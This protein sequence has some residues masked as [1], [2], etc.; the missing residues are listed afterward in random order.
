M[1]YEA[2]SQAEGSYIDINSQEFKAWFGNSKIVDKNNNPLVVY[3]GTK[4]KF[5]G[6]ERDYMG[7]NFSFRFGKGFYFTEIKENTSAYGDNLLSTYLCIKNP[8]IVSS[9]KEYKD[10]VEKGKEKIIADIKQKEGLKTDI[11]ARDRLLSKENNQ[12]LSEMGYDG[13]IYYYN[14]KMNEI[15]VFQTNQIKEIK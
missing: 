13:V 4:D 7:K 15:V 5:N 12:I 9:D 8:L 6:F 10:A 1:L 11:V 14:G 2:S 3:H